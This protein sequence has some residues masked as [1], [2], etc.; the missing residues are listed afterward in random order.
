MPHIMKKISKLENYATIHRYLDEIKSMLVLKFNF[1]K[2]A[3]W[4][5]HSAKGGWIAF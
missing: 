4:A 5:V 3:I 2:G 1:A